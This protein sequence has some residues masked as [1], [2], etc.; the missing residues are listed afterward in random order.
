MDWKKCIVCQEEKSETVRCPKNR[1][2]SNPLAIYDTFLTNVS[3][4]RNLDALPIDLVL[5]Q[6]VTK[7]ELLSNDASWHHSCHQ[8]FTFSRLER[9]KD[10]KQKEVDSSGSV[11]R[12]KRRSIETSKNFCLFCGI[13]TSEKL[14]EYSTNNAEANLRRM[15]TDLDDTDILTKISGGDLVAIEAKYPFTCLSTYRNRYRA[16]ARAQEKNLSSDLQR[17]KARAMVELLSYVEALIEDGVNLFSAKD[18]RNMYQK[19][20]VELGHKISVN[21]TSFKQTVFAHFE[22][23]GIQDQSD[24]DKRVYAFPEGLQAVLKSALEN[25]NYQEEAFLFA[26][27]AKIIRQELFNEKAAVFNGTFPKNCQDELIPSTRLLVSMIL[28]GPNV[29]GEVRESQ[30]C[31]SISQ[32]CLHNAKRPV[33]KCDSTSQRHTPLRE[34]P[35]PLYVGLNVHSLT[36]NKGIIENLEKLGLSVSYARILQVENLLA[37]NISKQFQKEGIVC[38]PSLRHGLYTVGASTAVARAERNTLDV[39]TISGVAWGVRTDAQLHTRRS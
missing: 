11:R 16:F 6:D 7:E 32:L 39:T 12:S 34:P 22:D 28:Y 19:R 15:A 27:V 24:G 9:V 2:N 18:L 13:S 4:F 29:N 38:P 37:H 17:A 36:R 20:L 21:K 30:A 31:H 33:R 14:T 26:K 35:V 5:P 3:E 1:A 10:R 8:K 23:L 25:R